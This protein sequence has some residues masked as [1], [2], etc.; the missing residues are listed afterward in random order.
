MLSRQHQ[1]KH[2]MF[3]TTKHYVTVDPIL[4]RLS[5][6]TAKGRISPLIMAIIDLWWAGA[7]LLLPQRNDNPIPILGSVSGHFTVC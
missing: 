5:P 6:N 1:P 4:F 2:V 7:T 3:Q